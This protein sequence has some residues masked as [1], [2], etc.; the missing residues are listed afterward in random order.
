MTIRKSA[1]KE[2]AS[3]FDSKSYR[4]AV[5]V[6]DGALLLNVAGFTEV[7][8]LAEREL[9]KSALKSDCRYHIEVLSA[10]SS[11]AAT[12][13]GVTVNAS[14]LPE[15]SGANFDTLVLVGGITV[16][17]LSKN[18]P[19]IQWVKATAA[20]VRRVVLLG[21]SVFVAAEAGL[22]DKRRC[23]VHWRIAQDIRDTYPDIVADDQTL[24][25]RDGKILSA[26]GSSACIDLALH[27]VEEDFGRPLALEI[28]R[29]LVLPQVRHGGLPQLSADLK[30]QAAASPRMALIAAWIGANIEKRPTVAQLAKQSAMSERNFSR[31]FSKSV[32]LSPLSYIE[33]TR[34][35]MARQLLGSTDLSIEAIAQRSGFANAERLA[36]NF[37]RR[38]GF[39][40]KD[41]RQT[42]QGLPREQAG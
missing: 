26:A 38:T 17:A 11:A 8:T 34:I 21:S 24:F 16:R 29:V 41:Y 36:Q 23:A 20:R 19:F 1:K 10:D 30:G 14:P 22:L 12:L 35:A 3:S 27:V 33:E 5:V 28:A 9:R 40:P 4:I 18:K 7:L 15:P 6:Y 2:T 31:A 37:R 13:S 42:H 25:L 32:G 39:T